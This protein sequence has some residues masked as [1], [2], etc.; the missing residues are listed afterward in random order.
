MAL[1]EYD[2]EKEP[3]VSIV[4]KILIDSI[5]MKASD[6]HFDPQQNELLIK[7]RINGT[8]TEYTTAPEN[9]KINILTRIKILAGMNITEGLLPQVG[10][11]SFDYDGTTTNMRVSSLP[12]LNG[13]KIVVHMSNY[14]Q[15]LKSISRIGIYPDDVEKIKKL[16]KE[17]QGIILI[18]GT[19]ASGK[20]TTMYSLLKELNSKSINIISIEDP[21]KMKIDGVNQ[22]QISPEKD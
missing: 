10:S 18:T 21:I 7:F 20:T 4:K 19:T 17:P 16:L 5:K 8:L 11:I 15:N 12:V 9:Y 14:A 1:K 6:I 3:T 22:V 13:E 2:F